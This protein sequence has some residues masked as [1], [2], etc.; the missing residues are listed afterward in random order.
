MRSMLQ[1]CEVCDGVGVGR[2][3]QVGHDLDP[4]EA[5]ALRLV[6]QAEGALAGAGAAAEA[7]HEAVVGL[8]VVGRHHL[9]QLE[10]VVGEATCGVD[11]GAARHTC[12]HAVGS[13]VASIVARG[14]L[15]HG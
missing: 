9:H 15:R 14:D 8:L 2:D 5:F 13:G 6:Q 10:V 1:F 12:G 4:R 11:L 7:A 3:G